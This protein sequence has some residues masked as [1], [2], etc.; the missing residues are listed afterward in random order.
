MVGW[1]CSR[2]CVGR[3]CPL[4]VEW[5]EPAFEAHGSHPGRLTCRIIFDAVVRRVVQQLMVGV[6][7]EEVF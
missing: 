5:L 7:E 4:V 3:H 1:R 6:F 2:Q